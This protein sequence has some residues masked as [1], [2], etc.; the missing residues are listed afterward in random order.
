MTGRVFVHPSGRTQRLAV[1]DLRAGGVEVFLGLCG[2]A[3]DVVYSDPPWNPGNEKWWRRHA[4][5]EEPCADYEGLVRAWCEAVAGSQPAHIFCEQSVN[6]AHRAYLMRAVNRCPAWIAREPDGL[7]RWR[8]PLLELWT[9]Q[10]GSPKRP[11]MLLHFGREKLS[12]D[13]S[14][15]HNEAMTRCV[16][17]G[18]DWHRF[19]RRATVGDPCMGLGTTSRMADAFDLH[20]VGTELNPTRLARTIDWL[21]KHGYREVTG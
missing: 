12:T 19:G 17:E 18:V 21:V 9:V 15:L 7:H 4:G 10:Y 1:A 3:L 6:F 11:N 2:G 14:G 5:E 8:W 20:C 13:P 16:F